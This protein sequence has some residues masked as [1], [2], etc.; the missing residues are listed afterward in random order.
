[1]QEG[2]ETEVID[3]SSL[4]ELMLGLGANPDEIGARYAAGVY[5][6]NGK[7]Y[8]ILYGGTHEEIELADDGRL[9]PLQSEP[10]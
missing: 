4:S 3:P 6:V 7:W 8:G 5:C 10:E 2:E 9:T 1:M